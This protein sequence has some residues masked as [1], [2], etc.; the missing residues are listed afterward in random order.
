MSPKPFAKK[1]SKK[2]GF[3]LIEVALVGVIIGM[4]AML[5]LPLITKSRNNARAARFINDL[6]NGV[7]AFELYA[8]QSGYYPE[9]TAPGVKPAD[10]EEEL[11]RP[12]WDK[13]TPIGGTWDWAVD[14]GSFYAGVMVV[15]PDVPLALLQSIDNRI[16]DGNLSS[17]S[18]QDTG[19]GVVYIIE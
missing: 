6:R 3:T 14:Q 16:D 5:A 11:R 4:L 12:Q 13:I 1:H 2:R 10:M 15:N 19:G 17:G 9:D 18:F 8:L 7:H